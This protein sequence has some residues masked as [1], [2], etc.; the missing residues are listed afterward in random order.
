MLLSEEIWWQN[1]T[2]E[3]DFS[4]VCILTLKFLIS[5]LITAKNILCGLDHVLWKV[6][7]EI[8]S[9]TEVLQNN[10][11]LGVDVWIS[12]WMLNIEEFHKLCVNT[13]ETSPILPLNNVHLMFTSIHTAGMFIPNSAAE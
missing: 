11:R 7:Q 2:N 4:P 13:L 3:R 9:I 6:Y 5:H 10:R 12:G 8:V 1:R